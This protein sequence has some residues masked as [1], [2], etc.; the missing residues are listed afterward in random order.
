MS[1][2]DEA[3][4]D[5]E[6]LA[7]IRAMG[8]ADAEAA[9]AIPDPGYVAAQRALFVDLCTIYGAAMYAS[10]KLADFDGDG[11]GGLLLRQAPTV[12]RPIGGCSDLNA[13][14]DAAYRPE[15]DQ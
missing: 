13:I 8:D 5:V 15:A 6:L 2:D 1:D 14:A 4:S 9:G 12:W 3:L 10:S 7:E 11:N